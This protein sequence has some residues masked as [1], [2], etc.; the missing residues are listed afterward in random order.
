MRRLIICAIACLAVACTP[1]SGIEPPGS[2]PP[3]RTDA[4]EQVAVV[5]ADL[6]DALQVAPPAELTATVTIDDKAVRIAFKSF[7]AALSVI[8]AFVATGAIVKNSP[9]AIRIRDGIRLTQRWL[10]AASAAQRVGDAKSYRAAL[11]QAKAALAGVQ[12]ALGR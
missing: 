3:S 1:M 2:A 10:N 8:D 6:A 9:T 5:A 11:E 7:D 4:I 12:S